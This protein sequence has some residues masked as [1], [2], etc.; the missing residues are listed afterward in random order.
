MNLHDA[1]R[2]LYITEE[3]I[4]RFKN[5][6]WA[7]FKAFWRIGFEIYWWQPAS[8]TLTGKLQVLLNCH[9]Q[10][11]LLV[12]LM[13]V[14]LRGA[15]RGYSKMK[16]LRRNEF[17]YCCNVHSNRKPFQTLSHSWKKRLPRSAPSIR[18][19]VCPSLCSSVLLTA[20]ANPKG[21]IFMK[22]DIWDFYETMSRTTYLVKIGQKNWTINMTT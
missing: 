7:V 8:R 20:C 13:F 10:F 15:Y 2:F 3:F 16:I 17:I 9:Q 5:P 12:K 4:L 18:L 19:S 14:H 11:S 22:F 1:D 6:H 21:R